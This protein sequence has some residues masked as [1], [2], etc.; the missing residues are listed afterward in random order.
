MKHLTST[1]AILTASVAL[2]SSC[3]EKF[4]DLSDRVFD[5][6]KKQCVL[7]DSR[8]PDD[9]MPRNFQDGENVDAPL[10]WWCSGFF[11]GTL[12]EIYMATGDGE[13]LGLAKKQTLKLSGICELDTHHDIGFQV[14]SSFGNA[15]RATGDSTWLPVIQAAA[16]KLAGRF[17]P[18]AGVTQSWKSS[19]KW[20][21]PVIIDNMMNLELL[22]YASKLFGNEEFDMIAR[23]HANTTMRNHFRED[24]TTWHVVAYDPETGEVVKKQTHQ[25]YSDD[26]AWSRGQAWALYGYTMMY[27]ETS[28]E[29][30]LEQAENVAAM[31]MRRLPGDSIPYWDFDAPDIPGALRDASAGAIMAS[32]FVEL[33]TLTKDAARAAAYKKLA[34]KQIRALASKKYLARPGEN[35]FFLLKHSVGS[36][37][38]KSEVDVPLSYADYYFL[39][40][41]NRFNALEK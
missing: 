27:R 4:S 25:G 24:Y 37:P 38:G 15:F 19:K 21:C 3:T 26:S 35:G 14:N 32:A 39:E 5:V 29:A 7:M 40:A 34:E 23:T 12:W 13:V 10:R 18:V 41:I 28:D 1:I 31:L 2:S 11:P 9:M 16:T 30:Y 33:S 8:L 36:L 6:A 22:E 20:A 17:N